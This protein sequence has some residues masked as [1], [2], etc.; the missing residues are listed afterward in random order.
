[1]GY[2][3]AS[4]LSELRANARF[5]R[6]TTSGLRESAPHDVIEVKTGNAL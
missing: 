5:T 6:I 2:V 3:G 4:N 1:M